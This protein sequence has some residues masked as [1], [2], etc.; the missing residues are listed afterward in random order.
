MKTTYYIHETV[1][2]PKRGDLVQSNIGRRTERTW[3]ILSVRKIESARHPFDGRMC[4]RFKIWAERWWDIEKRTRLALFRSAERRG[5]Q[6]TFPLYRFP[7][8]KKPRT[9]EQYMGA[10]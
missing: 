5:G 9:F 7:A 6:F 8:K 3:M 10:R 1:I 4:R 2:T